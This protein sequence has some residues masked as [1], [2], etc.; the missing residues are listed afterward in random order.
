MMSYKVV[1][2]HSPEMTFWRLLTTQLAQRKGTP[3]ACKACAPHLGLLDL[4]DLSL[5]DPRHHAQEAQNDTKE[6]KT[7]RK[8]PQTRRIRPTFM[9]RDSSPLHTSSGS[10]SCEAATLDC[11]RCPPKTLRNI[12][13][14]TWNPIGNPSIKDLIS[15]ENLDVKGPRAARMK[16]D[17]SMDTLERCH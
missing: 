14:K 8:P 3:Q 7:R 16:R 17:R 10:S 6:K 9:P 2:N 12:P 4:L 1:V 11:R 13:Q 15:P 5:D